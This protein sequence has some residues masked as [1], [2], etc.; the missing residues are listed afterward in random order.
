[1]YV[2]GDKLLLRVQLL[3]DRKPL[4]VEFF[5]KPKMEVTSPA[6]DI[7]RFFEEY[8]VDPHDLEKMK[9]KFKK[10]G[11]TTQW[12]IKRFML[13]RDKEA[14]AKYISV[15]TRSVDM[16]FKDQELVSA[17]KL[18]RPGIHRF[19]LRL[20]AMINKQDRIVRTRTMNILVHPEGTKRR[21]PK[22]AK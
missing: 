8:K 11:L 22:Q 12:E 16:D 19:D 10:L 15:E 4:P 18:T 3:H 17:I 9:P 1:M 6:I 14:V 20:N 13:S 7:L 2:V 21:D 5:E